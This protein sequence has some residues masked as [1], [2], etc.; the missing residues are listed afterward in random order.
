MIRTLLPALAVA[1]L[2]PSA[3]VAE[4][5]INVPPFNPEPMRTCRTRNNRCV[6]STLNGG[7]GSV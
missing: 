3:A 4:Q 6:V 2:A 5:T 1:S 7:N